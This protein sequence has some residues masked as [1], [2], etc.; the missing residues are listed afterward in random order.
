MISTPPPAAHRSTPS[1]RT[2]LSE[3]RAEIAAALLGHLGSEEQVTELLDAAELHGDAQ[4][5]RA[6]V[7]CDGI[8]WT[9]D[10]FGPKAEGA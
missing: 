6:R 1:P 10:L 5:A 9:A 8:T 2:L 3:D 4:N 7:T